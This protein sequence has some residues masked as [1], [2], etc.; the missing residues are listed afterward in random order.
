MAHIDGLIFDVD[1]VLLDVSCSY[2]PMMQETLRILSETFPDAT[3]DPETFSRAHLHVVKQHPAFNDDYDIPWAFLAFWGWSRRKGQQPPPD[4]RDW[5]NALSSC[6]A[7]SV[8]ALEWIRHQ[9]GEVVPREQV[10]LLCD[11]LYFGEAYLQVRPQAPCAGLGKGFWREER[12]L[13]HRSWKDLPFPSAIYTGR[14]RGELDLVLHALGWEDFP[15]QNTVTMDDGILKPSPAGLALLTQRLGASHPL[16]FG[17][18]ESDLLSYRAFGQGGFVA[19]GQ[20]LTGWRPRYRH[21]EE[22]LRDILSAFPSTK[23]A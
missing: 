3:H 16:Y 9:W 15:R 19:L 21:T 10:R 2:F 13:V 11:R 4:A 6:P 8:Q 22:A 23:G 20:V 5:K 1:G 18:A 14:P 12:P 17:D 7:E